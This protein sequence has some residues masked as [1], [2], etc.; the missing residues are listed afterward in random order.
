ML[1]VLYPLRYACSSCPTFLIW[2]LCSSGGGSG[3]RGL[4]PRARSR[5]WRSSCFSS[6]CCSDSR[7]IRFLPGRRPLPGRGLLRKDGVAICG[8]PKD[9]SNVGLLSRPFLQ[10]WGVE[11]VSVVQ[12][13][14]QEVGE[15][16]SVFLA[17]LSNTSLLWHGLQ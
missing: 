12:A 4:T 1:H 14:L 13:Y 6:F 10:G 2:G 5:C 17:R 15:A 7:M 9:V 3:L 16:F 11:Y 8:T